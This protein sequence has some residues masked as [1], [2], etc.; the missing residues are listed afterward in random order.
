[1]DLTSKARLVAG[2]HE[3]PDPV[4]TMHARV[5][6]RELVQI[7]LTYTALLGVSI[8]GADILNVFVT[9]PTAENITLFVV[10]S[11][12]ANTLERGLL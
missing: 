1:M 12:E 4:D 6:T 5:V 9:A 2:G 10:Q 7:I 8:C 11:S 3:T